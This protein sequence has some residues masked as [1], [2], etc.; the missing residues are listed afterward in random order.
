MDHSSLIT[1]GTLWMDHYLALICRN[2]LFCERGGYLFFCWS[3]VW[4]GLF[5][6]LYFN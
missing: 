1:T 6:L 3:C 4:V 2:Y 5:I